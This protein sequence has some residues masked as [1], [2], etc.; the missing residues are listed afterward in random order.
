MESKELLT[1]D[2]SSC[3]NSTSIKTNYVNWEN[4]S[5]KLYYHDYKR[6]M[7]GF[8]MIYSREEA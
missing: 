3:I 2:L 8:F 1:S 7:K 4:N 6:T 5:I